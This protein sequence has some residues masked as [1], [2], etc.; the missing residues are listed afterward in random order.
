[1]WREARSVPAM[2]RLTSTSFSI[3]GYLAARPWSAYELTKQIRESLRLSWTRTE[4]RLYQEPKNLVER[5]LATSYDEEH[6]GRHRTV[7]SIT[8]EGREELRA[9][10]GRESAPP[11]H[12]C[13]ALLKICLAEFGTRAAM[14]ADLT[15]TEAQA[16]EILASAWAAFGPYIERVGSNPERLHNLVLYGKFVND[17]TALMVS[18]S[19]WARE[20][21]AARPDNWSPDAEQKIMEFITPEN[22]ALR[23]PDL[24]T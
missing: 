18:W 2:A 8:D 17:Y 9:W 22:L 15:R 21:I 16:E 11:V 19:R 14:I 10:L 6:K 23:Y 20:Q 3:L 13:E 7:Y 5:G 12:E 1:V 24:P 4:A